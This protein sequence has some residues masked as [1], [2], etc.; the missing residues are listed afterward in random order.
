[1]EKIVDAV[2][3]SGRW[4]F[5]IKSFLLVA[6]FTLFDGWI[7]E[8]TVGFTSENSVHE[9]LITFLVGA[10]FG[11][12][13]MGIMA[14]QRRLQQQLS[15]LASTDAL[16][17]LPNRQS[18]LQ[19]AGALIEMKAGG[20]MFM[21]DV[22]HFKVINDTYGHLVGDTCLVRIG[23]HLQHQIRSCDLVG[24]IGGEEFA[25]YL[26]DASIDE[27]NSVASRICTTVSI[28]TASHSG[29]TSEKLTLTLSI[30]CAAAH[31]SRS[32]NDLIASADIAM[33]NAKSKGRARVEW[34][35]SWDVKLACGSRKVSPDQ[36][37]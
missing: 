9:S 13:V 31:P 5:V 1:M 25:V 28:K 20:A 22:D 19:D 35:N 30:G 15:Y 29:G 23:Q 37:F 34:S 32:L 16:T 36:F 7:S 14:S 33:Y 3:P 11:L 17:G 18:F 10:P 21:I 4:D 27:A 24:R 12:F 2:S 6:T 8:V 26:P